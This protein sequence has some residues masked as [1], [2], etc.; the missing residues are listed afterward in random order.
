MA[1]NFDQ[2]NGKK[3]K[4][5]APKALA[6]VDDLSII[7]KKIDAK[8]IIDTFL[9]K[10]KQI[11]AEALKMKITDTKTRALVSEMGVRVKNLIKDVNKAVA[12]NVADAKQYVKDN[13]NAGKMIIQELEP[14]KGHCAREILKDDERRELE[15][16]K[17]QEAIRKADEERR[18]KLEA[19]AARLNIEVPE[20]VEVKAKKESD[21]TRTESGLSFGRGRWTYKVTDISQVPYKYLKKQEDSVLINGEIRQGVRDKEDEE[22]N[23]IES[24]IPGIRIYYDK[25]VA[26]R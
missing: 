9:P 23:L 1:L 24:A 6:V 11:T 21:Q 12:D 13:T 17:R 15:E 8:T 22:G 5:K 25:G 2:L 3:P 4:K 19:E 20:V 16:K 10:A 18:K 14:G 26:F 7:L